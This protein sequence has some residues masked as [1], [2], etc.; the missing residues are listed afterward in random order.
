MSDTNQ[1]LTVSQPKA[2]TRAEPTAGDMLEAILSAIKSGEVTA[3]KVAAMDGAL[4]LCERMQERDAERQFAA[5]FVALQADMPKVQATK[6]VPNNDGSVRY[7]FAPFEELMKQ[8]GPLLQTHGFTVSF[9]SDFKEG[10]I[11]QTCT[12]QHTSGHKRSNSFAVRIGKGPPGASESQ[13]DGA[14]ATYAKRFALC[15]ALNIVVGHLDDDAKVEGG[16]I[17]PAQAVDL[18]NRVKATASDEARF[19][20][21]AGAKTWEEIP[22]AKLPLLE[23]LLRRK[24]AKLI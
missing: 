10:R 19:L 3:E 12:L 8:A 6:A 11:I 9:S 23:D 20:K 24:E 4:K 1:A 14:A 15:D 13:S 2:L 7:K 21:F 16:T 22:A 18:Y 17:T 5:A